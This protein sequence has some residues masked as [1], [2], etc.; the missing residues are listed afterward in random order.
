MDKTIH[1][2][3]LAA[4]DA[5]GFEVPGQDWG[6]FP[7]KAYQAEVCEIQNELNKT[8]DMNLDKEKPGSIQDASFHD[9]LYIIAPED[10]DRPN[11]LYHLINIR[12]SN[13]G[14][15]FTITSGL[16]PFPAQFD[17]AEIVC[18]IESYGWRYI[19]NESLDDEYDGQ[20]QKLIDP[21]FTWWHRL[22]DYV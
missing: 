6:A 18:I 16:D 14:K 17:L 8:L 3:L 20:N 12:F 7:Y 9:D 10:P 11:M 19:P 2:I 22:F 5:T 4:D 21:G 13:F 15:L 1:D